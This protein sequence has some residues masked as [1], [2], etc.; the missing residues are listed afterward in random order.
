MSLLDP[1]GTRDEATVEPEPAEP[2]PVEPDRL[3]PAS[4][5]LYVSLLGRFGIQVDGVPLSVRGDRRRALLAT[6]LLN[7]GRVVPT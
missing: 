3:E 1:P 5:G 6:L 4:Q 7:T 2:E